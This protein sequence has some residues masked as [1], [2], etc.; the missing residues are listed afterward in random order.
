MGLVYLLSIGPSYRL[1]RMRHIQHGTFMTL[2]MP[3]IWCSDNSRVFNR[4]LFY[5]LEFWYS[6]TRNLTLWLEQLGNSQGAAVQE[7]AATNGVPP[8]GESESRTR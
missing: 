1:M 2:Y 6:D 5:Y 7:G 4:I 8:K 3:T